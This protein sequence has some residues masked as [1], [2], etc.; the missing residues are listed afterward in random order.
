MEL[1]NQAF[2]VSS[3]NEYDKPLLAPST[4]HQPT[5]IRTKNWGDEDGYFQLINSE[6]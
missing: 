3:V 2:M 5:I 6:Y 4:I 1:E